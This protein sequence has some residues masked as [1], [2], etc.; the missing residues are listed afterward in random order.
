M[1]FPC[2]PGGVGS[3]GG[4]VL[5]FSLVLLLSLSPEVCART[6][7]PLLDD[8]SSAVAPLDVNGEN[9][10][11]IAR[12]SSGGLLLEVFAYWADYSLKFRSTALPLL[13]SHFAG[14]V[15]VGSVD[16]NEHV[17]FVKALGGAPPLPHFI[18][19]SP[20]LDIL[21][22]G[23][24]SLLQQ[25]LVDWLEGLL[26]PPLHLL[27]PADVDSL[28]QWLAGSR[29]VR[30]SVVIEYPPSV[31]DVHSL[32]REL[33]LRFH[34]LPVQWAAMPSPP[35]GDGGQVH[36]RDAL[37][38][39]CSLSGSRDEADGAPHKGKLQDEWL[40]AI[41][42][43]DDGDASESSS[44]SGVVLHNLRDFDLPS[45]RMASSY[46]LTNEETR[47]P[48]RRAKLDSWLRRRAKSST[49]TVYPD[50]LSAIGQDN[51]LILIVDAF[52]SSKH[53]R[54]VSQFREYA[55]EYRSNNNHIET[56][57]TFCIV[58]AEPMRVWLDLLG[59]SP[60]PGTM[61]A[62]D[63][64][65]RIHYDARKVESAQDVKQYLMD[66]ES[67]KLRRRRSNREKTRISMDDVIGR[68]KSI[69]VP[70]KF[71]KLSSWANLKRALQDE[72]AKFAMVVVALEVAGLL[73]L[74]KYVFGM[75][76]GRGQRDARPSK[77]QE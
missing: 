28:D 20:N 34:S 33:H 41:A 17:R 24:K 22:F 19:I 58:E 63:P 76:C 66:K 57:V 46:S 59:V 67:R 56:K 43:E 31:V 23:G 71:P 40:D 68:V 36:Q 60:T 4:F 50:D 8:D 54:L 52:D 10:E 27:D 65:E 9:W 12:S 61:F 48:E 77:K 6:D 37:L 25:D 45:I 75:C 1:T 49:V 70:E 21:H 35:Q 13:A 42:A 15:A 3:G 14:R 29:G 44:P 32:R 73:W 26:S 47:D 62:I 30:T 11:E 55:A 72:D 74:V 5:S 38:H 39:L 51:A 53:Q 69:L 2:L 16:F 18:Y 64:M 7:S